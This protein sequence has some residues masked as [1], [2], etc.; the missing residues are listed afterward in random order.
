MGTKIEWATETWNPV[1][2]CT[3][4]SAACDHCYALTMARRLKGMSRAARQRG[5]NPGRRAHYEQVV[6][7]E[8]W[9]R[10]QLVPEALEDPLHWERS[11]TVFVV[12]MG[13]LFHEDVPDEYIDR[14]FHVMARARHHTFLVLTKRPARMRVW[15]TRQTMENGEGGL[16]EGNV[17][18][19]VTA[20]N[21]EALDERVLELLQCPAP[22]HFVSIEP[23]LGPVNLRALPY[24]GDTS[25]YLDVL[26]GTYTTDPRG[27]YGTSFNF[28][29]C[30]MAPLDW[31]IAG[32]ET[33]PGARP[34]DPDW[35]MSLKDQCVAAGAPFFFKRW[36][37]YTPSDLESWRAAGYQEDEPRGGRV[38]CGRVWDEFPVSISAAN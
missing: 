28:G 13:D 27:G 5:E 25:Y 34:M 18:L 15:M 7:G 29:L 23:M 2:G 9:A 1:V 26:R 19:G 20:E 31:V 11:R 6:N 14:I 8:G 21:Q 36:G 3:K 30:S 4:V 37:D 10:V 35:V 22:V 12:S 38:L 16:N 24:H 33:G 32:G 17:W